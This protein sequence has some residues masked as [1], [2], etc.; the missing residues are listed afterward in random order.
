VVLINNSTILFQVRP[1]D[2]IAQLILEKTLRAILEE[3]KDL[4]EMIRGSQGFGSTGLE[5]ILN[6]RIISTQVP[7][8]VL[9][10]SSNQGTPR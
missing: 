3:K 1:G 7:S 4:S 8:R 10:T 5:E 2:R 9:S 6:M